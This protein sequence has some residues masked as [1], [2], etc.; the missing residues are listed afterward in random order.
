[1]DT[2]LFS[3]INLN[4]HKA[5]C[6][7]SATVNESVWGVTATEQALCPDCFT[8]TVSAFKNSPLPV[9]T[10]IKVSRPWGVGFSRH[11]TNNCW[12]PVLHLTHVSAHVAVHTLALVMT[13]TESNPPMAAKSNGSS[14]FTSSMIASGGRLSSVSSSLSSEQATVLT[15]IPITVNI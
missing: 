5:T 4:V 2:V 9:T 10:S 6:S 7:S 13:T 12:S 8:Y 15:Q 11:Q 14:C 3:S 1:M